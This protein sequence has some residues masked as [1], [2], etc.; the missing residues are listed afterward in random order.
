MNNNE[1]EVIQNL[2]KDDK[3][4]RRKQIMFLLLFLLLLFFATFGITYTLYK[5]DSGGNGSEIITDQIIFTYSDVDKSGNGIYL[6]DAVAISDTIGK[7]MLGTEEYFDFS[8]T[9]TSKNSKLH[10]KL[11]ADKGNDSTLPNENVRIYLTS[12]SGNLEKQVVL[13]T[14]SNLKTERINGKEYYVLYEK[15]LDKGISNYSD[16]YRLRMWVKEDAQDYDL[17]KFSLKVDV[18]AVQVGE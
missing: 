3:E 13:D 17:K 10:Y 12:L 8:V 1:I 14:F 16:F 11:L 15:D 4:N 2:K 7:I 18:Q 5:G 9:A 6:K